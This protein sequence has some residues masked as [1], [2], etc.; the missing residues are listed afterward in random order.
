MAD[1]RFLKTNPGWVSVLLDDSDVAEFVRMR[2]NRSE[3]ELFESLPLGVMRADAWR[4]LIVREFGGF[5]ADQDVEMGVFSN[6]QSWRREHARV[7]YHHAAA[8]LVA[9]QFLSEALNHFARGKVFLSSQEQHV[10]PAAKFSNNEALLTLR[11]ERFLGLL[12]KNTTEEN[13]L[14]LVKSYLCPDELYRLHGVDFVGQNR[15]REIRSHQEG[16]C[17]AWAKEALGLQRN[18]NGTF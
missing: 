15:G 7:V 11:V 2:F 16:F 17:L 9:R 5:Y 10:Q 14:V 3:V 6:V 8:Q 13:L 18:A 12:H 4:Y 1:L